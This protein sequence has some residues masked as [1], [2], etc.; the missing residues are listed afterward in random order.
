MSNKRFGFAALAI[1]A[2]LTI[3]PM[4][5]SAQWV[6]SEQGGDFDEPALRLAMTTSGEY[7]LGLRCKGQRAELIFITPDKSMND[8]NLLKVANAVDPRLKYRIDGKQIYELDAQ[9]DAQDIGMAAIANLDFDSVMRFRDAKRG[10]SVVVTIMGKNYHETRFSASGSTKAL[11]DIIAGCGLE[12]SS[13]LDAKEDDGEKHDSELSSN[14]ASIDDARSALES[15]YRADVYQDGRCLLKEV[16]GKTFAFC[17]SSA[18]PSTGGLFWLRKDPE[19]T[20]IFA[21]NGKAKQHI[22]QSETLFVKSG[23]SPVT[24]IHDPTIDIPSVMEAFK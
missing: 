23:I 22:G 14:E 11:N 18:S 20:S 7:G 5:A 2:L 19:G 6:T 17:R 1:V 8:P 4:P 13:D 24:F 3:C 10:I 9:L 12:S 16:G 21:V 15:Y